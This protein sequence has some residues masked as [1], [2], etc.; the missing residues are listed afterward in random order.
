MYFLGPDRPLTSLSTWTEIVEAAAGGLL[1]EN[2]WC[3]LK[4]TLPPSSSATNT[5]LA[6]GLASLAVY[7]GIFII[8]VDDDL[9]VVGAEIDGMHTRI[10]QV[11]ATRIDPPLTPHI[12]D[13]LE[14]PDGKAVLIVVIPPSPIRPHMVDGAYWGRSSEGKRK[15]GDAE[16]RSLMNQR[17]A[18]E[19]TFRT[20]LIRI[21]ERDPLADYVYDHPTG[22]GHIYFLATPCAPVPPSGAEPDVRELARRT[23]G[24]LD[25]QGSLRGCGTQAYDPE[26]QAY[27]TRRDPV[28]SNYERDL[29]YV[30]VKDQDF[31]VEVVSGAGSAT[32]E[33]AQGKEVQY[34]L[35]GF[36]SLLTRQ[37]LEFVRELSEAHGYRGLWRVGIRITNLKGRIFNTS[38]FAAY[39]PP[40]VA[41]DYTQTTIVSPSELTDPDLKTIAL[42]RGLFR[43]LGLENW[44]L[45]DIIRS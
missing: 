16:V 14:G 44:S 22:N 4:A 33:H 41:E 21:E 32:W 5:E 29:C 17:A 6:R 39:L 25:W 40:F 27:V 37:S 38:N 10:S 35:A 18:D 45:A 36:I 13:P 28:A 31:S 24:G 26:G 9:N 42:L 43:G 12:L 34:A 20:Q 11:A 7:G 30:R 2:A 19:D 15:L 23:S 3:E 1:V 8:G